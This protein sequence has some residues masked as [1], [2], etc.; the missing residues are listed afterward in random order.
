[1]KKKLAAIALML[2]AL[3]GLSACSSRTLVSVDPNWQTNTTTPY[4]NDFYE[5][6][7]YDVRFE[8][9]E[10]ATNGMIYKEFSGTYEVIVETIKSPYTQPE[11]NFTVSEAYKL[12]STLTVSATI[13]K[14]GSEETLVSFG[15]DSGNPEDKIVTTVWFRP[16][17]ERLQPIRTEVDLYTHTPNANQTVTVY[18]YASV[19]AYNEGCTRAQV[20]VTDRS[21]EITEEETDALSIG[22]VRSGGSYSDLQDDYSC[23]DNAQLYFAGRGFTFDKNTS[24]TVTV[25]DDT[26]GKHNVNYSCSEVVNVDNLNFTLNT[27]PQNGKEITV[28]NVNISLSGAGNNTGTSKTVQYIHTGDETRNEYHNLPVRIEEPLP[29]MMGSYVFTLRYASNIQT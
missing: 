14:K 19:T 16:A 27:V 11:N 22:Q 1:M 23:F 3:I 13:A 9:D 20:T 2:C 29:Y 28:S 21:E 4:Q 15:G 24:H 5:R 8:A 12:T 7:V 26:A 6:T 10:D 17:S 25:L 18:S